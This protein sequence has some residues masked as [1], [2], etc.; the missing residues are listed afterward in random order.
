MF[1]VDVMINPGPRFW[2]NAQGGV[3]KIVEKT[4]EKYPAVL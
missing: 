3:F 1:S 2:Q 4:A